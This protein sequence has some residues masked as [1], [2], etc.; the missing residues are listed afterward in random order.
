MILQNTGV[1]EMNDINE[2]KKKLRKKLKEIN[3][4]LTDDY[5]KNA[6]GIIAG[7]CIDSD[8]FKNADSIFIYIAMSSEPDTTEII[9]AAFAAGKKVYVP[10]C[11]SNGIMEAVRID[12]FDCLKPGHYG[13]YEPDDKLSSVPTE[14]FDSE[15]AAAF[16][17]CVAASRDGRRLGHGAGY[18]DRFLEGRRM[19][20]LMLVY[21]RQVV[22]EIPCDE[23]DLIMDRVISE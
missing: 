1:N 23:H 4:F 21:G 16:V 12:S 19:K 3:K 20:R 17:P 14:E 22:D 7:K 5:K 6:S 15:N 9:K 10:R 18:Y 11:L 2:E 8:E 13:I